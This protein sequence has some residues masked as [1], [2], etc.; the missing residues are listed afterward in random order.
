MHRL[1]VLYPPPEDPPKFREYYE[2]MH[3]KLG[4]KIPNVRNMHFSFG[5]KGI[6]GD[7]S[8]VITDL[9]LFCVFMAEWDSEADMYE[10]LTGTPEG[11]AV[12]A[13]V[14]NYAS[15]AFVFHYPMPD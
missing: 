2:T 6:P 7:P 11:Q 14:P 3:S 9:Q 15:K 13:D 1:V 12:L 4:S 5:V 8:G 10:A